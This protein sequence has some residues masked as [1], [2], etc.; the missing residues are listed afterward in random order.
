[1]RGCAGSI[2]ATGAGA[3]PGAVEGCVV[4]AVC[5]VPADAGPATVPEGE[6]TGALATSEVVVLL[7]ARDTKIATAT[8]ATKSEIA[9]FAFEESGEFFCPINHVFR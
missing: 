3:T 8:A 7:S 9:R 5:D 1:M 2:V 4:L 6:G